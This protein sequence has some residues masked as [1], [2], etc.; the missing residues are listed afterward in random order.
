M[1]EKRV[2][3]RIIPPPASDDGLTKT[4]GTIVMVG[5]QKLGGVTGITLHC[6]VNDFWRATINCHVQP[7]D[8]SALSVIYEPTLWQRLR[9]WVRDQVI[10]P[11][12]GA[13]PF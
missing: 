13:G 6:E 7:T 11:V 8:L 3:A 9:R 2:M 4:Q 12:H 10:R 5:D 1:S